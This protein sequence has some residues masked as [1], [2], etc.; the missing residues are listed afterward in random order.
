MHPDKIENGPI[1]RQVNRPPDTQAGVHVYTDGRLDISITDDRWTDRLT[2]RSH[3]AQAVRG[4][5]LV[6]SWADGLIDRQIAV[7]TGREVG[8]FR[9]RRT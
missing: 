9:G 7:S 1:D 8:R 3:A 4:G 5:R 2:G 6:D